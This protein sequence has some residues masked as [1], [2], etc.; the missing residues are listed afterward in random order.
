MLVAGEVQG[1][2][3][4][5]FVRRLAQDAGLSG[6]AENLSDGRVEVVAEGPRE[7]LEALLHLLYRG[8]THAQVAGVDVAW[9]EASGLDGFQIY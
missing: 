4:R 5:N 3:Y 2:N 1:V 7:E 8:P 6:Y 9:G